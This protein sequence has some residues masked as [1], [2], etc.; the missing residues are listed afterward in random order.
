MYPA[1]NLGLAIDVSVTGLGPLLKCVEDEDF[2]LGAII[3][4][5]SSAGSPYLQCAALQLLEHAAESQYTNFTTCTSVTL[6]PVA[7]LVLESRDIQVRCAALNTLQLFL[8]VPHATG[9]VKSEDFLG[10]AAA[11]SNDIISREP[12]VQVAAVELLDV[13]AQSKVVLTEFAVVISRISSALTSMPTATQVTALKILEISAGS[14]IRE[15][16]QAVAHTFHYLTQPIFSP[17]TSIHIA[18]LRVLEGGARTKN[19]DLARTVKTISLV[20]K[21]LHFSGK[22]DYHNTAGP[23]LEVGIHNDLQASW[24]VSQASD[25]IV[26]SI[27]VRDDGSASINSYD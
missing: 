8:A 11:I 5:L 26:N 14:N 13:I 27:S 18:A 22:I 20:V 10:V 4:F 9:I 2:D 25:M 6:G 16:V 1:E 24:S 3:N 19:P 17:E 21:T 23:A 15:L 7:K 12:D